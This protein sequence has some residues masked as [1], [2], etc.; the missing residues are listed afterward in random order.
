MQRSCLILCCPRE[1][2]WFHAWSIL[3]LSCIVFQCILYMNMHNGAL[4]MVSGH[5]QIQPIF[6]LLGQGPGTSSWLSGWATLAMNPFVVDQLLAG[7]M[8]IVITIIKNSKGRRRI[9]DYD[10]YDD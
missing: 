10:D 9:A 4:H 3:S 7:I 1:R 6:P 8:L 5:Y 2:Y